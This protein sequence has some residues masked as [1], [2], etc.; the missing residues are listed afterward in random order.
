[1][2]TLTLILGQKIEFSLLILKAFFC[3][4]FKR[5]YMVDQ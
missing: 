5:E 4:Y 3:I 1:M 2:A